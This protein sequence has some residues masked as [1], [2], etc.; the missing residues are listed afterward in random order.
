MR[1]WS[2]KSVKDGLIKLIDTNGYM[3]AKN[4]KIYKKYE[5]RIYI[6]D[7]SIKSEKFEPTMYISAGIFPDEPNFLAKYVFK[8]KKE[9]I[10]LTEENYNKII[11]NLNKQLKEKIVELKCKH[12]AKDFVYEN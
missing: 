2:F 7:F 8:T 10:N 5:F 12:L 11:G 9:M 1:Y 6:K 4:G 3:F